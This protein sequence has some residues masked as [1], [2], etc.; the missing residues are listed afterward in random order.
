MHVNVSEKSEKEEVLN[1]WKSAI[2]DLFKDVG[3]WSSEQTGW[4]FHLS[5]KEIEE[6]AIGAYSVPVLTLDTPE[7]RLQLEPIARMV[8]GG[9]G[10]VELYA[11]PT[12]YRVRLVRKPKAPAP[13]EEMEWVVLSDGIRWPR[14]FSQETFIE[15][16]RSLLD[17]QRE[18]TME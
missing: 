8:F 6:E 17:A 12:L 5:K 18:I 13:S 11:W 2:E 14:P 4:E 15:P 3:E 10:A 7:G 16:A 9:Q 1:E